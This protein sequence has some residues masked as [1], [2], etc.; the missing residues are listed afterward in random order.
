[1]L[2]LQSYRLTGRFGQ[3]GARWSSTHTGLDFAA[4]AGTPLVAVAAG[5][6]RSA[7]SSGPYGQRTV[8]ELNDGTE[9]WYCH[10][11]SIE[12]AVGEQVQAGQRIGTVG[13]TGN[14]TGPHLHLEIRPDA[15]A[16]VDPERE[17]AER[18]IRP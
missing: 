15:G 2:P 8:L 9:V 6:V 14:V 10:Q 7:G 11:A 12:V 4:P 1:M 18:G 3:S 5:T 13:A 17:L 16:P